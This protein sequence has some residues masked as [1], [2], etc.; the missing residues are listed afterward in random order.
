M[1]LGVKKKLSIVTCMDSRL[2]LSKMLG[3]DI[4]DAEV[5]RNAGGRVTPDVIRSLY[6]AQEVPELAT[7]EVVIIHHTDCGAQAAERHVDL[8]VARAQ[9]LLGLLGP[10]LGL[11]QAAARTLVPEAVRRFALRTVA[12]TFGDPVEAVRWDVAVLRA[13]P[14]MRRD[15]PIHGLLYDVKTGQL[16]HVLTSPPNT[17]PLRPWQHK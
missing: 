12:R 2:M 10:L 14:L 11:M 1:S 5:I 8:L 3:L 15:I 16:F 6:V 13:A 4:G 7:R 17:D 9:Q